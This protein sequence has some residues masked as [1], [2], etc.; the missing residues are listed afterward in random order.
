MSQKQKVKE[1]QQSNS[2]KLLSEKPRCLLALHTMCLVN[3]ITVTWAAAGIFFL[4]SFPTTTPKASPWRP[5]SGEVAA[6]RIP[7]LIV[8]N[9]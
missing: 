7:T 2:K 3:R 8:Y 1:V 5:N 6:E 4:V 9:G